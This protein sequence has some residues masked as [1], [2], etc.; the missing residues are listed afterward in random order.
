MIDRAHELP[1]TKQAEVLRISRGTVPFEFSGCPFWNA[2]GLS[3]LSMCGVAHPP[4][5]AADNGYN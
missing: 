1:I 3:A 2:Q 4:P 5:C